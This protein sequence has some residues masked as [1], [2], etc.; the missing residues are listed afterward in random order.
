MSGFLWSL[1]NG[2]LDQVKDFV[3][4]QGVDINAS[5]DGRLPIHYAADYGQKDVLNYLIDKGA[6]IDAKDKY[7][8]S[9]LLAAIWE[10]HT[11]CVKLMLEK[12]KTVYEQLHIIILALKAIKVRIFLLKQKYSCKN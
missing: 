4:N 7:G 9:A 1:T 3:E 2:D 10:G 5:I 6:N 12:A 11:S 8:I